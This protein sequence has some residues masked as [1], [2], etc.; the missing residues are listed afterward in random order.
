MQNTQPIST[1][2]P[3]HTLEMSVVRQVNG[4]RKGVKTGRV[5]GSAMDMRRVA[6][7]TFKAALIEEARHLS[8]TTPKIE[9]IMTT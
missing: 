8:T 7:N 9:I 1:L 3:E 2:Y 5:R 4:S 6:S